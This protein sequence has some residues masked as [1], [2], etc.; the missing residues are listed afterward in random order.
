MPTLMGVRRRLAASVQGG[1][2]TRAARGR[3]GAAGKTVLEGS[4]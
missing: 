3:D 1:A 4:A 2:R